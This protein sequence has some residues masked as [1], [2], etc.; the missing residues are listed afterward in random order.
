MSDLSH[1]YFVENIVVILT[2]VENGKEFPISKVLKNMQDLLDLHKDIK[3]GKFL[4]YVGSFTLDQQLWFAVA[5]YAKLVRE[6]GEPTSNPTSHGD[7]LS[8]LG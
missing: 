3:D 7:P 2:K 8:R 5:K 4:P 1:L 6:H